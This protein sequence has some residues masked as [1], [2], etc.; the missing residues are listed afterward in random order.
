MRLLL[1]GFALLLTTWLYGG[2][3]TIHVT[4]R[5][6]GDDLVSLYRYADLFT[7]RT[8]LVTRG[9]MDSTGKATL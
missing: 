9:I 3:Y 7:H 1:T 8:V 5:G 4:A 2:S 6:F